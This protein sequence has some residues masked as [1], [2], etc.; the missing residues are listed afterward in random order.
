MIITWIVTFVVNVGFV[1]N[2]TIGD[3]NWITNHSRPNGGRT[4]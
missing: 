3:F 4:M 2:W 1:Q